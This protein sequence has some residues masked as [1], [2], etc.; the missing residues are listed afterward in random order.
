M[1]K[2]N[3]SLNPKP[4]AL[5]TGASSGIGMACAFEF[6]KQGYNLALAARNIETLQKLTDQLNE[7]GCQA[8]AIKT[9][10]SDPK[11]CETFVNTAYLHF[12]RIDVLINN[13]G[14]SMRALFS[15]LNLQ[16][17]QQVMDVN[18]WGMV[19]C[20]KA[21][22]PH[23]LK[24]NGSVIGI[25]SVAGFVGLPGRTGYS[26]SKFAM[27]GF[28]YALRTENLK[29]GLHVGVVAPGYTAS[30]I[31]NSALNQNAQSQAESPFDES[32]LMSAEEV[33]KEIY[34][35]VKKRKR[36]VVLTAQGKLAF[37]LSKIAPKLVEILTFN[38]VKK[39]KDSPF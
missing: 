1:E 12:N 3:L 37:W 33:A 18:F 39:E 29:T 27:E 14:I 30:N 11:Q 21:A 17:I 24:Q 8:L 16:V 19:Y 4:V 35:V 10:V 23:L 7:L 13:A 31:R 36:F 2:I 22:L 25:S 9:D 20:T 26:A 6:A 34:L 28:L 15:Q 38:T 5:I 32:K